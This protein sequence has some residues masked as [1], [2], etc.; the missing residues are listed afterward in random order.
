MDG[1]G[2]YTHRIVL[3]SEDRRLENGMLMSEIDA[4][5]RNL[6]VGNVFFRNLPNLFFSDY[7]SLLSYLIY[8]VFIL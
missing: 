5:H 7:V 1:L 6:H 2:C 8:T 4:Q 3:I